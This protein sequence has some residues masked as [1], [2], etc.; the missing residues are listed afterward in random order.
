MDVEFL[1]AGGLLERGL[2]P[3]SDEPPSVAWMLHGTARGPKLERLMEGY[4][5]LRRVEARNRWMTG[6]GDESLQLN[7][8]NIDVLAEL[9]EPGLSPAQLTTRIEDVRSTIRTG[10]AAVVAAGTIDALCS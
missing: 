5:F 3:A 9:V 4:H 8:E 1:A 10:Y 2:W 6:R 7:T